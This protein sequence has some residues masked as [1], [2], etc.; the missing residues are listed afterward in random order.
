MD[1]FLKTL[2]H[3]LLQPCLLLKHAGKGVTAV[4]AYALHSF[5]FSE[6]MLTWTVELSNVRL[7]VDGHKVTVGQLTVCFSYRLG[8]TVKVH[9][10]T[11]DDIRGEIPTADAEKFAD[12]VKTKTRDIIQDILNCTES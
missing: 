12:K 6:G 1:Y 8:G 2:Q 5:S 3:R 11:Q 4:G 10:I 7:E 9:S